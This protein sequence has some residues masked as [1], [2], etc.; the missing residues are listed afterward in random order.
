MEALAVR[1]LS[2][3][4]AGNQKNTIENICFSL[5]KGDFLAV[6]G[7]TG[8]GKSTLLRMLKKELRPNG[9]LYGNV[10]VLGESLDDMD[11]RA[12]ASKVGFVF[13]RPEQQIVTDKVWHELAFGLE[14]LGI[15]TGVIRR[16]VSEMAA[17]FGIEAWFEKSVSELSGG[18]KQLLNLAAVMVM[19]P[20]ILVLDEPTAQLD[21]ISASDFIA[22]LTKLNRELGLTVIIAEHRLEDVVPSSNKLLALENGRVFAFGETRS[23]ALKLG[24]NH[25]L[26]GGM[27]SAVRLSAALG[28][29]EACPLTVREGRNFI[30][31][32]FASNFTHLDYEEKTDT[33]QEKVLE[34]SD[35]FFRYGSDLPDVLRGLDLCVWGGEIFCILG[36]NGSGKSTALACASGIRKPYSGKIRVFGKNIGKYSKSELYRNCIALLPQDAQTL[37]LCNTV[38]EELQDAKVEAEELPFDLTPLLDYHPY[39]LSGGQQQLLALAK[40]LAAKPKILLADEPTKGL[41]A[42]AKHR[43]A[44]VFK[45]LK[46]QGI[47]VVIVTHDVEFAAECADRCAMF[48]R[49]EI[50]SCEKPRE[51]FAGNNFYTTAANRMTR[52]IYSGVV[53]VSDAVLLALKNGRKA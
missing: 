37:F 5:D 26:L 50:T 38:R 17:Y 49:G 48:F 8:S 46:K 34:F 21:P 13:Q 35:V 23:T 36:G 24:K 45:E 40:V 11:V 15:E 16:R 25:L 22:T 12:S 28:E 9:A 52:G 53:T 10:F 30:E 43:V 41:D 7:A 27:P 31:S 1:N 19:Q 4:Y 32:N 18:Q 29:K 6:C 14:N 3:A 20:E 33:S 42:E 2:F 44:D 39:D 47:S 51:F